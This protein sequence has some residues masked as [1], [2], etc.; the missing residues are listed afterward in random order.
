MAHDGADDSFLGS[1]EEGSSV[2]IVQKTILTRVMKA[3]E[4]DEAGDVKSFLATIS[5]F[6][7]TPLLPR[8]G[9]ILLL[10]FLKHLFQKPSHC[11]SSIHLA[12][13]TLQKCTSAYIPSQNLD[14]D[15]LIHI[16]VGVRI[17]VWCT[18]FA[19][20]SL[21]GCMWRQRLAERIAQ[22]ST[23]ESRHRYFSDNAHVLEA[24]VR[25]RQHQHRPSASS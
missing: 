22:F 3:D 23:L 11:S 18:T 17:R 12:Y 24:D 4:V 8:S 15:W 2:V 16:G 19:I 6:V 10:R 20:C 7:N 5:T 14:I 9:L 13:F 1:L 21:R 25:R